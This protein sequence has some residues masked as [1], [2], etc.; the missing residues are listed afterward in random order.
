MTNKNV[1]CF[2]KSPHA[3]HDWTMLERIVHCQGVSWVISSNMIQTPPAPIPYD[4]AKD[5]DPWWVHPLHHAK[6]GFIWL[7]T[8][9]MLFWPEHLFWT[10]LIGV[11][12]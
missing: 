1:Q 2:N 9:L 5:K 12:L 8:Q 4:W 10:K 7:V 11:H 6:Y 3:A